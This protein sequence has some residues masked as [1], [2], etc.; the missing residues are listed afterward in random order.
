MTDLQWLLIVAAMFACTLP[1]SIVLLAF[2]LRS[3]LS[4]TVQAPTALLPE[5]VQSTLDAIDTKL[6]PVTPVLDDTALTGLVYEAVALAE[7]SKLKGHDRFR[8]AQDYV[9]KRAAALNA[10]V[11]VTDVAMR[12]EAAVAVGKRR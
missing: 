5:R 7:Q 4:I 3:G 8:I 9:T 10:T 1:G 2:K 11:N 6:Q 12:I